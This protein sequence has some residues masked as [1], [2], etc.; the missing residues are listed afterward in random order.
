LQSVFLPTVLSSVIC[1]VADADRK[2]LASAAKSLN[3]C[4]DQRAL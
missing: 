4:S 2:K 1:A 3:G